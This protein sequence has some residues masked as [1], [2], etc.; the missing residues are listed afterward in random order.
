MSSLSSSDDDKSSDQQSFTFNHSDAEEDVGW[1]FNNHENIDEEAGEYQN[2]PWRDMELQ[3]SISFDQATH[4]AWS[5]AKYEITLARSNI[6]N[7]LRISS[8]DDYS[9]E[10]LINFFFGKFWLKVDGIIG[11]SYP[12]GNPL[13]QSTFYRIL[14]TF[15]LMSNFHQS[16]TSFFGCDFIKLDGRCTNQ[17]YFQFWNTINIRDGGNFDESISYTC[18]QLIDEMNSI[19]RDLFLKGYNPGE[20]KNVTIDDDKDHFNGAM[21]WSETSGL[22]PTQFVRDNRR[23]FTFH[24]LIFTCSGIPLGIEAEMVTDQSSIDTGCRLLR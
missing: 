2:I 16:A 6:M 9:L 10:S 18:Q 3:P 1:F 8:L 19:C 13:D 7:A 14:I 22:K 4:E 17:Q 24:T 11:R 15:L 5:T 23:G 20:M 21:R 12:P